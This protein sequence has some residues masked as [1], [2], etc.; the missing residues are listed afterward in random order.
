MKVIL[1]IDEDMSG[2]ASWDEFTKR[3]MALVDAGFPVIEIDFRNTKRMSSLALGAI[4]SSDQRMRTAGR[5]L[6]LT[7]INNELKVLLERTNVPLR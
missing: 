4:V 5:S 3:L 1:Q 2:M 6:V 7:N